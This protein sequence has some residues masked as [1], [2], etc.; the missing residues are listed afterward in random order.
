[1]R[2]FSSSFAI[3]AIL[4]SSLAGC[5]A[6]S[7]DDSGIDE[8][9]KRIKPT[10]S[11][12]LGRLQVDWPSG[13]QAPIN[14][15]DDA[16]VTYRGS[17]ITVG[18]GSTRLKEGDGCLSLTSKFQSTLNDCSV[19]LTKNK[20]TDYNLSAIKV[21]YDATTA[22][23]LV[24][25]FGPKPS[26]SILKATVD[27]QGQTVNQAIWNKSQDPNSQF[28]NGSYPKGVIALAGD[29]TFTFN[30]PIIPDVKESVGKGKIDTVDIN[31][32]EL[33][34]TIKVKAPTRELPN[35]PTGNC[36]GANR[37]FIVQR[38]LE[39]PGGG[40]GE[41]DGYTQKHYLEGTVPSYNGNQGIVAWRSLS[42]SQDTE[43]KVFPFAA[44]QGAMHYEYIVN[45]V[46][47]PIDA[48]PGKSI[49]INVDRLDVDDVEVEKEDG[50]TYLAKGSYVVYREGPNSTW[51]P[52]TQVVG[53]YG[54]CS[55]YASTSQLT[56]PTG[57]GIDLPYGN[58]RLVISY[59]TAEGAKTKDQTFTLP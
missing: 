45:G 32:S 4:A 10:D 54:D 9:E 22:G 33:R 11:E 53:Q 35:A 38:S 26:L 49:T 36:S 14:A 44:S 47:V 17:S 57:Y 46:V 13:W 29:Y 8:G 2:T 58:Y 55:G 30:L 39:N 56:I 15:S 48:K 42:L 51:I 37:N 23:K 28:F 20:T 18:G 27:S 12:A 24:S 19:T 40:L 52:I 43:I 3:L 41:P 25:D 5:T 16:T 34:T 7:A 6:D 21:V 50:T 31:P 1:M 59:N